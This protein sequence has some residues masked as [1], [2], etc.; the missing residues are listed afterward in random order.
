MTVKRINCLLSS[1]ALVLWS[2]A[3]GAHGA[4]A[5]GVPDSVTLDGISVGFSWNAPSEDHARIDALKSCLDLKTAPAKAR[6]LCAVVSTFRHRCFSVAIDHPGGAGWGWAVEST[7]RQAEMKALQSC[8]STLQK[9]CLI[10]F[11]QC[12]VSP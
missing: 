11:A 2:G 7:V 4:L 12:D 9:T 10:A 8:K 3:A 1:A 5:I 6:A